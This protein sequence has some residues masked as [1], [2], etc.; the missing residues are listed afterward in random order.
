[1]VQIHNLEIYIAHF[2]FIELFSIIAYVGTD[3]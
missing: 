1:M 3:A 2:K